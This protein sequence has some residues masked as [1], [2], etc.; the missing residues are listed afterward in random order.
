MSLMFPA[1]LWLLCVAAGIAVIYFLRMPRRRVLVADLAPWLQVARAGKRMSSE[2]RTMIS[3]AFQLAIVL[4]LLFAFARPFFAGPDGGRLELVLV[5]LSASTRA[6]DDTPLKVLEGLEKSAPAGPSRLDIEKGALQ[7]MIRALNPG[8]R[9]TVI[10]VGAR[11]TII[12][13]GESEPAVLDRD[14]S[15]LEARN[16]TAAFA[17]ACQLAVELAKNEKNV[18]VT[19]IDDGSTDSAD[20]TALNNLPDAAG[21]IRCVKVGK[22]AENVGIVGFKSRK[23]FNSDEI[24][25]AVSIFNSTRQPL[26]VPVELYLDGKVQRA[27]IAQIGAGGTEVVNFSIDYRR[28]GTLK[29][30]LAVQDAIQE[31]NEAIDFLPAPHRMKVAL[32][33]REPMDEKAANDYYLARVLRSDTGVEGGFLAAADYQKISQDKRALASQFE[34]VVF[35]NWAPSAGELPPCHAL[36]VNAE[37]SEIPVVVKGV[38]GDK[39]LIRKWDEGHPLMNYLNL[40][41]VFLRRAK[42][43]QFNDRTTDVVAELVSSPLILARELERH[44]LVYL[45]FNPSDSDIQFKKEL[46]LFVLN[47]FEWFKRG[48]EPVTQIAPGEAMSIPVDSSWKSVTVQLPDNGTPQTLDVPPGAEN[49]MFF[50]TFRPGIYRYKGDAETT[51]TRGFAVNFGSGR[52]SNLSA[53]DAIR[54]GTVDERGAI[55]NNRADATS[56]NTLVEHHASASLWAYFAALACALMVAE[57]YLFHRRIFF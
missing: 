21:K 15:L 32:V 49:I 33:T 52:A 54:I 57:N 5:N 12:S 47:A 11:T 56:L 37:T 50:D 9:M 3:L 43:L 53:A 4:T 44:K 7:T 45:G 35:D 14:V 13:S 23:K 46:P 38:L 10:G 28:G 36:F 18:R 2:R 39:P 42:D 20:F 6:R 30:R 1:G 27:T 29:A 16:E 34:A 51:A 41:D 19:V 25:T 22:S 17:S 48:V 40:R 31:D 24:E 8:D 55:L 26:K